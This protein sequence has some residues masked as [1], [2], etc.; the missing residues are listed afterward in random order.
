MNVKKNEQVLRNLNTHAQLSYFILLAFIIFGL[1]AFAVAVLKPR[2]A[3]VD[4]TDPSSTKVFIERCIE[5][6]ARY[7]LFQLGLQGGYIMLPEDHASIAHLQ[8]AYAFKDGNRLVSIPQM[9]QQL[10]AFADAHLAD[11]MDNGVGIFEERFGEIS[12]ELPKSEVHI[13]QEDVR[14]RVEFP[15]TISAAQGTIRYTTPYQVTIPVR[16]AKIREIIAGIVQEYA[17]TGHLLKLECTLDR[18]IAVR[19]ESFGPDNLFILEDSKSTL[20]NSPDRL[21]EKYRFFF[22]VRDR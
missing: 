7:A 19:G 15:I 20:R 16:L 5:D 21:N 6:T 18:H 13:Q 3:A 1:L 22:V 4:F 9:E 2:I 12:Y 17:T 11:C 10:A 8:V 14:F